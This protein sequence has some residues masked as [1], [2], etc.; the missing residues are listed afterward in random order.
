MAGQR[1]PD[2]PSLR[3]MKMAWLTPSGEQN[4]VIVAFSDAGS[5]WWVA[6]C[7]RARSGGMIQTREPGSAW[8]ASG[9]F[10]MV[11]RGDHSTEEPVDLCITQARYTQPPVHQI[12]PR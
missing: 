2:G 11:Y 3:A 12:Q 9:Q 10:V 6:D 4:V 7:N 8:L 5:G 1:Q